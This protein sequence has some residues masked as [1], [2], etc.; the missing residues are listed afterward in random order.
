MHGWLR[1]N[2]AKGWAFQLQDEVGA[3]VTFERRWRVYSRLADDTLGFDI[4]PH[5]GASLGNVQTFANA[6]ATVRLGF[7]L[8]S[9]FG[10]ELIAGSA[11]TNSPTRCTSSG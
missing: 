2:Q 5:A 9:D 10:I 7:N 3:N 11:A 6:G 8:P 1:D 4:V